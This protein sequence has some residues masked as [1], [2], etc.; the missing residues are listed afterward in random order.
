MYTNRMHTRENLKHQ[1]HAPTN[2]LALDLEATC[3]RGNTLPREES[4]IIEIGAVLVDPAGNVLRS[5][6]TYVKPVVHR[7]ITDF[8]TELT[9]IT[10]ENVDAAPVFAQAIAMFKQ[11]FDG[12]AQEGL[13]VGAWGSWG[14]YD[15]RQFQ[16]NAD[17][18]GIEEKPF[19]CDVRYFNLKDEYG[20]RHNY[21]GKRYPGLKR[22]VEAE[23][24]TFEGKHHTALADATMAGKLVPFA[25]GWQVGKALA[26]N[27]AISDAHQQRK[28]TAIENRQRK[29][30]G[31][32]DRSGPLL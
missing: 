7:Q 6:S 11:W 3:D 23:E 20:S 30:E 22:A 26:M 9:G 8:C 28:Q 5:F 10:Q 19:I 25:M 18:L 12:L 27:Q 24:L 15:R 1:K 2:M 32:R 14:A 29:H 13:E 17:L 16:R 21:P 4:E 31:K